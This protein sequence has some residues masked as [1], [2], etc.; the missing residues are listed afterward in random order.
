H[1]K[2]DVMRGMKVIKKLHVMRIK[3]RRMSQ[4][5]LLYKVIHFG[6]EPDTLRTRPRKARLHGLVVS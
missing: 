6:C 3:G 2:R 1:V 4:M 5:I